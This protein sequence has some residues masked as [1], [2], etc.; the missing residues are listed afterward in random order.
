MNTK[1]ILLPLLFI[2]SSYSFSAYSEVVEVYKYSSNPE[3]VSACGFPIGTK[4]EPS[5]VTACTGSHP[6]Y[7]WRYVNAQAGSVEVG[8][9]YKPNGRSNSGRASSRRS[10]C[11]PPSVIND[12]GICKEPPPPPFCE[13]PQ[14]EEIINDSSAACAASGGKYT[15]ECDNE[16]ESFTDN[17]EHPPEPA[18][19]D[20]AEVSA[21]KS[22]GH[23]ACTAQG[24]SY[25]FECNNESK[26]FKDSCDNIPPEPPVDCNDPSNGGLPECD[27]PEPD[28]CVIGSP[29]WPQCEPWYDDDPTSPVDPLDP[30]KPDPVDPVPPRPV[31]PVGPQPPTQPGEAYN[32]SRVVEAIQNL[33]KD[34]NF[35]FSDING[36]LQLQ[37][38]VLS[39]TNEL[40]Y[41]GLLQDLKIHDNQIANDNKNTANIMGGLGAI[42]ESINGLGNGIGGIGESI[43]GLG[44]AI[45]NMPKPVPYDDSKVI[46]Q[47][48][49]INDK[50]ENQPEPC[51]PSEENGF[52]E[53]P[54]GLTAEYIA[55]MFGQLNDRMDSE[56]SAADTSILGAAKDLA[57]KPPVDKSTVEPFLDLGISLLT[58]SDQCVPIEWFDYELSC[59]FS[60]KFKSIFGFILFIWTLKTVMDILLE[61]IT[62]NQKS[63]AHRRR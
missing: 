37:T 13:S 36:A 24:G 30:P 29:S 34:M 47:L 57:T 39:S 40:V 10:S 19:C 41:Q 51:I 55:E 3:A 49:G 16:A 18:Y 4:Y 9:I 61:D 11:P 44:E 53:G 7:T 15:Y 62:P 59:E 12:D 58:S 14:V 54:N 17:C 21:L 38:N 35:G 63:Y 45:G 8:F 26:T 22:E 20:S 31:D 46:D 33:N 25:S 6:N 28:K 32:D 5:K 52:C 27:K 23:K 48:Q 50:L 1:K 42:G 56:L 2:T 43:D 60:D